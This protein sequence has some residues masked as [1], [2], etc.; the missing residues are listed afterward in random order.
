MKPPTE[1]VLHP[2]MVPIIAA[3]VLY[4]SSDS[5]MKAKKKKKIFSTYWLN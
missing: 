3:L 1:L 2:V 4:K 5:K